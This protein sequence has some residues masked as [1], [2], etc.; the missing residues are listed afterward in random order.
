ML[1]VNQNVQDEDLALALENEEGTFLAQK[2]GL[3]FLV[4]AEK[5]HSIASIRSVGQ[6][7]PI[8][9]PNANEPW[10]ITKISNSTEV[11]MDGSQHRERYREAHRN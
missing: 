11:M 3:S 7:L 8:Q 4:V 1:R 5:G 10:F 6:V 2:S 9:P